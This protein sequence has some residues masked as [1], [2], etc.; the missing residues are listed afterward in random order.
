[1][2]HRP[3]REIS[4][5]DFAFG[6]KSI[7]FKCY[8]GLD[9]KFQHWEEDG[10]KFTSLYPYLEEYQSLLYLY[11]GCGDIE[12]SKCFLE[13]AMP[14]LK[15]RYRDYILIPAP[16]HFIKV[17]ARGFD[18]VPL[19]FEGIGKKTVSLIEKT[20]DIKQSDLGKKE[21]AKVGSMLR[22]RATPSLRKEKILFVDDVYTTGSTAR[23]CLSLIKQL[24]PKKLEAFVMAKVPKNRKELMAR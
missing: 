18:H 8:L 7:C 4:L 17:A 2:C 9:P 20:C 11:K 6:A 14:Y 24:H 21:R 3:I 15:L 5:F 23:A 1:M 22:L 16:S 12:L 10:V 13:R 19:M